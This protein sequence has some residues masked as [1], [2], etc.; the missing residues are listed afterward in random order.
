MTILET[1]RLILRPWHVDDAEALYKY[2]SDPDIGSAAGWPPHTSI[3]MSRQVICE[4]F[5]APET[6]AV[7]LKQTGQPI[8]CCGLVPPGMRP[9]DSIGP[10]D[11]EIGYWIGKPYWGQG[12][13]PEAVNALI[14]HALS[15]LNKKALWI[16]FYTDNMKSR[17]VAEKCGFI[18]SHTTADEVFFVLDGQKSR[19]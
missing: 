16:G 7:V 14:E 2:A 18:Y 8:G 1:T 4:Y 11:A 19:P 13:I 12:L 15:T 17:R 6:Y 5:S 10:D 9:N 3:S